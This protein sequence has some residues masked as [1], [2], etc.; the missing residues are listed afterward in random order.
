MAPRRQQEIIILDG[1]TGREIEA[2]GGPFRQ[3]E[4]SALALYEAPEIVRQVHESFLKA[5]ATALTTNTYAIVPFH[6]G[7]DRY[8]KD[9]KRL[10]QLA[11]DL[12]L[13]AKAAAANA[14]DVL[15]LGCIPPIC[16]SY[17]AD[18]FDESVAGPIVDDF[19]DAFDGKVQVLLLET[20]GS[21][22][23]AQFYLARIAARLPLLPVWLSF[24]LKT[25]FGQGQPP[26][27][28]TGESLTEAMTDM[29]EAVR[30]S[31]ATSGDK[32]SSHVTAVLV[33]CCD[34]RL[35]TPALQELRAALDTSIRIGAYPNAF[36]V[37][38]PDA[39]NHTL[40][41]VDFNIRPDMLCQ[42][43]DAWVAA[44]ATLLG[45]CCGVGPAHIRAMRAMRE[46]RWQGQ[47]K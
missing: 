7:A 40:R 22:R 26:V 12:A 1:G 11:V 3:P 21:V 16:G 41:Q 8:Q 36:S 5:G 27:L 45:G 2:C 20:V 19:L 15:V 46:A 14:E 42:S 23:E 37:P 38:P 35:V 34:V 25:E 24:C 32:S 13:Q 18:Q 9:G 4:W 17:E 47:S 30:L 28:L 31:T 29:G 33:N 39:A 43:A 44:G 6:L 10:L